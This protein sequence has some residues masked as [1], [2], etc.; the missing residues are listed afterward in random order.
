MIVSFIFGLHTFSFVVEMIL[1]PITTFL[2]VCIIVG[3]MEEKT[4]MVSNILTYPLIFIIVI[5]FSHSLYLSI[6][7]PSVIFTKSNLTEFLT[8]I[9]LSLSYIPFIYFTHIYQVYE[10]KFIGIRHQI[11]DEKL[12]KKAKI[13]AFLNFRNDID[14]LKRWVRDVNH[15]DIRD[16]KSLS[17]SIQDIKLRKKA[18]KNPLNIKMDDGWSPYIA[19][20][21]L[22]DFN[23]TTN[24]Y[25]PSDDEWLANSPMLD[26]GENS[27]IRDNVAYYVYGIKNIANQ[28]KI[29]AHINNIPI[30]TASF[31][32]INSICHELF[33]KAIINDELDIE[34]LLQSKNDTKINK[35]SYLI[36]VN[37]EIFADYMDGYT[38]NFIISMK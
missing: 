11:D 5:S 20:K 26:I 29:R 34:A 6:Q 2:S 31:E 33:H 24:D 25:H 9:I 12:Y 18:E 21:F 32:F 8:P 36:I 23:I 4:K 37:R 3:N 16:H 35:G 27:L 13:M 1:L 38:L 7:S 28:L 30:S 10:N 22:I 19:M 17:K 14:L 15:S